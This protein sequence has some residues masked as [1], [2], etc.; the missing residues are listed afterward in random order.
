MTDATERPQPDHP[1]T[2]ELP[3][4][5]RRLLAGML[6]HAAFDGWSV[7]ALH[8]AARDEG[9]TGALAEIAFPGGLLEIAEFFSQDADRR[10]VEAV[11]QALDE[12]AAAAKAAT[13]EPESE[14]APGG[15]PGLAGSGGAKPAG[16]K[17][18]DK[19][20]L[21]VRSRLQQQVPHREALRAM[22]SFLALPAHAG[23]ATR[24]LWRTVDAMWHAI[25]DRST[26]ISYYSKR[27]LLAGV[28]GSTLLVWLEDRS[29]GS[30]DSL[31]F[32]DR[33]IDDVM[34]FERGKARWQGLLNGLAGRVGAGV[35][36]GSRRRGYHS[37]NDWP[38][39]PGATPSA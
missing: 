26:D 29:E 3:D 20:A 21:A 31:A 25:G 7:K 10:M 4:L 33:R 14:R 23:H 35:R 9:V 38:K 5:R 24:L 1:E 17:I 39:G 22:A 13:P 11:R 19:I 27:A 12:A 30:A 36:P 34:A 16:M 2:G 6:R 8:A 15:Q 18:R 37:G 32:L 28:Y